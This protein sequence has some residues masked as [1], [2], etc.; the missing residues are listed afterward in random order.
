MVRVI[1]KLPLSQRVKNKLIVFVGASAL[2]RDVLRKIERSGTPEDVRM[3]DEKALSELDAIFA[4]RDG[5]LL[6][7]MTGDEWGA[8]IAEDMDSQ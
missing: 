6:D 3:R 2:P 7:D 5:S 1:Q 4:G 8:L